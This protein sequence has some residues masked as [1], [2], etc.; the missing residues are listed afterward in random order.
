MWNI[1]T[2]RRSWFN[3]AVLQKKEAPNLKHSSLP[4]NLAFL[5]NLEV[6][7][8]PGKVALRLI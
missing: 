2:P 5:L 4:N 1:V 6:A 7:N 8:L 3:P